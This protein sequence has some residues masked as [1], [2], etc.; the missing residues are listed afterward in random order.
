MCTDL[1][2]E[3]KSH[4]AGISGAEICD[5]LLDVVDKEKDL[6]VTKHHY[7]AF[8]QTALLEAL[9]MNLAINHIYLC[10]SLTDVNIHSTAADAV[11]H[12]LHVTIVEDCLGFRRVEEHKEA[13][14]QMTEIM[15]LD[16][17]ECEK[18]IVESGGPTRARYG[19]A[20]RWTRDEVSRKKAGDAGRDTVSSFLQYGFVIPL[21]LRVNNV[22]IAAT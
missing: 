8:D 7:S 16:G 3:V 22:T 13:K 12:R 21:E 10:G 19:T 17:I 14:R 20:W 6:M 5:E 11:R 18:V 15:G 2:Q 4:A 1:D 9:R